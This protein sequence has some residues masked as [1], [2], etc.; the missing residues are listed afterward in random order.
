MTKTARYEMSVR[1]VAMVSPHH[2]VS[3]WRQQLR[4]FSWK[5]M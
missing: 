5:P 4:Q 1:M 3:E 2:R